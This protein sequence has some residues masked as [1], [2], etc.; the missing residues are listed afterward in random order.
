ME[1]ARWGISKYLNQGWMGHK[2]E[3]V[4]PLFRSSSV[5]AEEECGICSGFI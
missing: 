5:G 2:D 3:G 1:S 4:A